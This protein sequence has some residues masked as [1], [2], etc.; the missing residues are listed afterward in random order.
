MVRGGV[1]TKMFI[2]KNKEQKK[3]ASFL[4]RGRM[5]KKG[6]GFHVIGSFEVNKEAKEN[7]DQ[8]VNHAIEITILCKVISIE[9]SHVYFIIVLRKM[10]Y[11]IVLVNLYDV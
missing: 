1:L 2:L 7:M 4:R 11:L 9:R 5:H 8:L 3:G 10:F 6:Q